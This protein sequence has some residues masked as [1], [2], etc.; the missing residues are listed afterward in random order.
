MFCHKIQLTVNFYSTYIYVL[1]Q[2]SVGNKSALAKVMA[3]GQI[4]DTVLHKT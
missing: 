4:D 2:N 1:S 3:W